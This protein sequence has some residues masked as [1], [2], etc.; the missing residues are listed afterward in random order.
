MKIASKTSHPMMGDVCAPGFGEG[1]WVV[2]L[3][4]NGALK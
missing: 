3:E 4:F 2:R 1:G